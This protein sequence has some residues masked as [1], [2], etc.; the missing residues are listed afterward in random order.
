MLLEVLLTVSEMHIFQYERWIFN[1]F[2][3][4]VY[5]RN[6]SEW[7]ICMICT[8]KYPSLSNYITTLYRHYRSKPPIYLN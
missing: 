5:A 3:M 7:D 1:F 2:T 4:Q 6:V 8:F